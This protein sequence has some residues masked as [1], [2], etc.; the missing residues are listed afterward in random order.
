MIDAWQL[1]IGTLVVLAGVWIGGQVAKSSGFIYP[2][3]FATVGLVASG[4]TLMILYFANIIQMFDP[5]WMAPFFLGYIVGYCLIG[6]T[7]YVQLVDMKLAEKKFRFTPWV[8]RDTGNGYVLFTQSWPALWDLWIHKTRH[9][10]VS[11]TE[12]PIDADWLVDYKHPGFPHL[13]GR[14]IFVEHIY[15]PTYIVIKKGRMR[16]IREYTT[17]VLIAR[18]SMLSKAELA[19][20]ENTI[21]RL[22]EINA[23]LEAEIYRLKVEMGHN[24]TE[25]AIQLGLHAAA[26]KPSMKVYNIVTEWKAFKERETAIAKA[27]EIEIRKKESDFIENEKKEG[28]I[29]AEQRADAV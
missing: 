20:E 2:W 3:D 12:M 16:E 23:S 11:V 9:H 18:A 27:T 15:K 19:V 24:V 29:N 28:K 22:Q 14:V 26:K 21:L 17:R 5:I 8:F 6:F 1:I 7:S 25:A 13:G 10:L 4:M